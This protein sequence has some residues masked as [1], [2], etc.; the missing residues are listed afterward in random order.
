MLSSNDF[1]FIK[2]LSKV[3]INDTKDN[4]KKL[5]TKAIPNGKILNKIDGY[6]FVQLTPL[7]VTEM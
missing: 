6:A 3:C 4:R 1:L 2:T 7:E 5:A